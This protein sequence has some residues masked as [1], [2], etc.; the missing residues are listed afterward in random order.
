MT[1]TTGDGTRERGVTLAIEAA[2]GVGPLA[3]KLG[4]SQPSVSGWTRIP[5]DRVAAVEAATGV[6]RSEL[7]PDLFTASDGPVDQIA[8]A[9]AQ[10]YLLLAALLL[11]PPREAILSE[12]GAVRGDV[13]PLG[14]AHIA[15]ADAARRASEASAGAEYFKL[16][17]GVGR[18]ELLPFASYYLS[19]FLNERPLARVREDLRRLGVERSEGVFEPEDHIGTLFEVMAGLIDG[20]IPGGELEADQFFIRHLKPWASRFF[21]D[22]AIAESADFYRAVAETGRVWLELETTALELEPARR[23]PPPGIVTRSG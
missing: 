11:Q 23:E 17:I 10:E 16:F 14:L 7:R 18:G 8:E 15:L 20:T 21:A 1:Q 13:T 12:I 5:A 6:S 22:L 9:R 19:G 3:R 2:G 4:I